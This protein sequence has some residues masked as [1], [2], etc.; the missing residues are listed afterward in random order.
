MLGLF[1]NNFNDLNGYLTMALF[2]GEHSEDDILDMHNGTENPGDI[3]QIFKD[4][5]ILIA[6]L[7]LKIYQPIILLPHMLPMVLRVMMKLKATLMRILLLI[8]IYKAMFT[9]LMMMH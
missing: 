8:L 6:I 4:G 7:R 2:G 1:Y 5:G 9:M 3:L